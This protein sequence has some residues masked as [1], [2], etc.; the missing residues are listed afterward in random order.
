MDKIKELRKEYET[1]LKGNYTW[2]EMKKMRSIEI[3]LEKLGILIWNENIE[4]YQY[5]K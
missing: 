4:E 5:I 1:L 2:N 3:E